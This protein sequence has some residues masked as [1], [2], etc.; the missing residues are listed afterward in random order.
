[1]P[2]FAYANLKE[3]YLK[4]CLLFM[5]VPTNSEVLGGNLSQFDIDELKQWLVWGLKG[6]MMGCL[7]VIWQQL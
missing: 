3:I 6:I 2:S 5:T 4:K 1:M 7:M